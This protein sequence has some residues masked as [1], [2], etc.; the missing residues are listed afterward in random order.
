MKIKVRIALAVDHKGGWSACGW[1]G[2]EPENMMSSCVD[3]LEPNE[4]RYWVDVEVDCP[5][6]EAEAVAGTAVPCGDS[7]G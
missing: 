6:G 3:S 1:N 4:R 5:E 7:R 2:A